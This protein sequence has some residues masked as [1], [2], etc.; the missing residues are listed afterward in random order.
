MALRKKRARKNILVKALVKEHEFL[1]DELRQ[2]WDA[3]QRGAKREEL[4]RQSKEAGI[5]VAKA[6]LVLAAISGVVVVAA[7]AP[8]IFA[9][10][11]KIGNRRRFFDKKQ[12]GR[13]VTHLQKQHLITTQ[14]IEGGKKMELTDKGMRRALTIAYQG[15]KVKPQKKWDGLWRIVAFDIPDR[16]KWGREY[17]RNKLKEMGFYPMQE[18]IFI[19]PYP[20]RQEVEPLASLFFLKS[21]MRFIETSSISDDSDLREHFKV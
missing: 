14:K 12:F 1:L 17:F 11:G 10:L 2:E 3:M 18:S 5:I 8:N 21:Y 7:V 16:H 4:I 19:F 15:L 20:C 6:L 9:A 13:A